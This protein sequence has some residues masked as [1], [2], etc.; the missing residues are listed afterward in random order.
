MNEKYVWELWQKCKHPHPKHGGGDMIWPMEFAE[1]I[2]K[3]CIDTCIKVE[4]DDYEDFT[5]DIATGI[6]DGAMLC[7]IDIRQRF[8]IEG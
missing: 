7:A 8:G 4:D 1:L 2:I 3:E 5:P 6:R